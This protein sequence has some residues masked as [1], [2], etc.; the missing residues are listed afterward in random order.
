MLLLQACG[1]RQLVAAQSTPAGWQ[2]QGLKSTTPF[3][4]CSTLPGRLIGTSMLA[5]TRLW[6]DLLLGRRL[7]LEFWST[8]SWRAQQQ[9]VWRITQ[10]RVL[11]DRGDRLKAL[12]VDWLVH[13]ILSAVDFRFTTQIMGD[14]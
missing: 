14:K 10:E 12:R 7:S 5:S 4:R 1:V 11:G 13:Q 9:S 3:S 2:R 6:I 8:L